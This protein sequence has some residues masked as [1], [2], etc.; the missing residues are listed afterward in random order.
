MKILLTGHKGFIGQHMLLA[1]LLR[2]HD[3][4]VYDWGDD[5]SA[6]DITNKKYD[7]V[8]HMGAISS[9]TETDIAK[10]I[11]QNYSFSILLFNRCMSNQ[12]PFQFSSSASVYGDSTTFNEEDTPSPL[13]EYARTKYLFEEY[14][15]PYMDNT[16]EEH[17][18]VQAFRY[19][20]VYGP[21]GEE[22]K[23]KQA[24]PFYQFKK[25]YEE[26]GKVKV[27][28]GSENFRR[29][30]IHVSEVVDTHLKFLDITESGIWNVGTGKTMSFMEVAKK[31]TDKIETIP[32]PENLKLHYQK[33]T[34]ADMTKLNKTLNRC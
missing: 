32:M 34:C 24:S 10:L 25:Q 4:S 16:Y 30:F 6:L 2:N 15:R 26:T 20:N 11:K 17:T 29:D 23:G 13:N 3:V 18:P 12:I 5:E 31:F 1:L 27:F 28:E 22:H 14:M 33:Y 7:R 19:F 8:I 9:T 21:E